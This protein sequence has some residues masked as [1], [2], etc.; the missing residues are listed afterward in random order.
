MLHT[1]KQDDIDWLEDLIRRDSLEEYYKLLYQP[2]VGKLWDGLGG[3]FSAIWG[4]FATD[5]DTIYV[6]LDDDLTYI[7]HNA[8]ERMV[9]S[10]LAHPEAYAILSNVINSRFTHYFHHSTD[11]IRP[12]LPDPSKERE[13]LRSWKTSLL[14][15]YP[16]DNLPEDPQTTLDQIQKPS[17]PGSRWLPLPRT[18]EY[19]LHTPFG[20]GSLLPDPKTGLVDPPP[21]WTIAL[22]EHYSF[23][24]ALEEGEEALDKYS[25]GNPGDGLWNTWWAHYNINF[26]VFWGSTMKKEPFWTA[27][28]QAEMPPGEK[29]N[30]ELSI[31]R[32]A[33]AKL[34]MPVYVDT[35]ALVAHYAFHWGGQKHELPLTDV[36]DR[37]R[38]LANDR[39]CSAKNQKTAFTK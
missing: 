13:E 16:V 31:S 36:L 15:E 37:Y 18:A 38:L 4:D 28:K 9:S 12:F 11:A 22:Q 34:K 25:F 14:P 1:D 7:H 3:H 17:S 2:D 35:R 5:N 19:Q 29:E 32:L 23:L 39:V 33:P 27:E 24:A 26:L 8:I 10:L 30:D 20:N 21:R 6:K